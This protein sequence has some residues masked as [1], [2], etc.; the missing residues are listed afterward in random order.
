MGELIS[1]NELSL[2]FPENPQQVVLDLHEKKDRAE[3]EGKPIFVYFNDKEMLHYYLYRDTNLNELAN[4]S[5][6]TI[7][8]YEKEL[9]MMIRQLLEYSGE[10]NLDLDIV[11]GSLFKSMGERHMRRYQRWVAE[12][13]PHVKK[14]G[15][16]SV[17][18]LDRKTVIWKSFFMFLHRSGYIEKPIH[19]GLLAATVRTDDRPNRDLGPGE[20]IQLL[21]Y[22][23]GRQQYIVFSIIHVL[24]ATGMRNEEL[25]KLKL[26]DVKYDSIL[27]NY[28]LKVTGKGN[29]VREI[30]LK[31]KVMDSII[32]YREA[33]FIPEKFPNT[34]DEP[35]FLTSTG[36][37]FSPD[38]LAHYLQRVFKKVELPFVHA[39]QTR[40]TAHVFRHSFAI[41]S[42]L[43]KVDIFAI[44]KAL[45]HEN[46]NTTMIYLQRIMDRE[47]H[48][49]HKWDDGT[50]G[51]YI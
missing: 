2:L 17:A 18:T 6:R 45:G 49:I 4:R 27:G 32:L 44:M 50:L 8:E 35:L 25:C 28:Y 38:G 39:R 20:V 37:A 48:A 5:M 47:Q 9:R 29:K 16:Y 26:S 7:V 21:D 12:E 22:F 11:E 43:N 34:S 36:R 40:I 3:K 30:P 41:I 15:Q 42:Y 1:K 31:P 23:D 46:I 19:E 51:R 13:S 24:V 10:I 33:R 14:R